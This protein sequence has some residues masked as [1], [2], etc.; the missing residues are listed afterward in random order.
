MRAEINRI[1]NRSVIEKNHSHTFQGFVWGHFGV[2]ILPTTSDPLTVFW[3]CLQP[4]PFP[5]LIP[6][7]LPISVSAC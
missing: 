7:T 1:E 6:A 5:Q 2:I 4:F 3:P